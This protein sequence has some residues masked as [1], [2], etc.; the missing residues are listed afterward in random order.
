MNMPPY[1][2]TSGDGGKWQAHSTVYPRYFRCKGVEWVHRKSRDI[3]RNKVERHS[4]ARVSIIYANT[5]IGQSQSVGNEMKAK[6][7]SC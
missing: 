4:S 2:I 1:I 7:N 6:T 5:Q 3:E